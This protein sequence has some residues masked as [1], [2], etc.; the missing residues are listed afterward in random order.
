MAKPDHGLDYFAVLGEERRPWLDA[1]ALKQKFQKLT[2]ASHPDARLEDEDVNDFTEINEGYR[3][4]SD[5]RLR[6]RHLLELE[7]AQRSENQPVPP[8]IAELFALVANVVQET[9][10]L[11]AKLPAATNV[12]SKS[13]LHAEVARQDKALKTILAE[14]QQ[15]ENASLA[16]LRDL[17]DSWRRD[18][19][20]A[21]ARLPEIHSRLA[22]LRR[23]LEQLREREFQLSAV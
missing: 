14:L 23:W 1:D 6:L 7:G 10:A 15:L 13:L 4:L 12:L 17:N 5:A 19:P 16:E 8:D 11:L 2:L 22:Y 20:A 18:R 9:G 3:V 21:M